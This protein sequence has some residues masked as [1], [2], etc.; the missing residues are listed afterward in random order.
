MVTLLVYV[1]KSIFKISKLY[2]CSYLSSI[3][4]VN[5]TVVSVTLKTAKIVKVTVEKIT[6][7]Y[8]SL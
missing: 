1:Y 3:A 4:V 8:L 6:V 5:N 2:G 7:V